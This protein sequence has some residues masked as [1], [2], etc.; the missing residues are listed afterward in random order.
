M[1]LN[2]LWMYHD[3]MDL[4]GDRGNIQVLKKRCMDRHI[5]IEI[6]TCGIGE[7][8]HIGD[9][10]LLFIGGGADREQ[11]LLF[12]DLVSRKQDI[13][14]AIDAKTFVLLICGGYQ[15]F[16]QYYIDNS[17][18]KIE[19]LGIF[20]YYTTS[21]SSVGRCIGNIEI[22]AILDGKTVNIVGFENHGGQ[23][24]GVEHPLGKVVHGHG[25][26]YQ[27]GYEGFYNGQVLGTY[28]H[29]PLLPKNPE[30]ADFIISKALAKRYG[31][32]QLAKLDDTLENRA[33]E[34]MQKRMAGA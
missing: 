19:G 7:S 16:G 13:I 15:F 29:G 2:V 30:V 5:E 25:N 31:E 24:R 6:D 14:D 23:T 28:M 12:D 26:E 17:N 11:G 18:N 8:K 10:D 4:Y 9:Y 32:V 3:V 1:K 21:D 34:V 27:G 20:N 33:H 22:E